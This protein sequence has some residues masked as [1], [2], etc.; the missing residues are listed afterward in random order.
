MNII[1]AKTIPK[2]IEIVKVPD[3]ITTQ[4]IVDLIKK[5]YPQLGITKKYIEE[6]PP[7]SSLK[8]NRDFEIYTSIFYNCTGEVIY[9]QELHINGKVLLKGMYLKLPNNNE[10]RI[11]ILE[12]LDNFDIQ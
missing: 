11:E 5:L 9:D 6:I 12:N 8:I 1:K 4:F 10:T 3:I 7:Q 2:N